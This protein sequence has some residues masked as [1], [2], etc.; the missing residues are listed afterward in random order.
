MKFLPTLMQ[1]PPRNGQWTWTKPPQ[2]HC[3]DQW[4]L[5]RGFPK[6]VIYPPDTFKN[7]QMTEINLNFTFN[8]YP[9]PFSPESSVEALTWLQ[10]L[11]L[12]YYNSNC[13]SGVT[14]VVIDTTGTATAQINN[15]HWFSTKQ[16]CNQCWCCCFHC[17]GWTAVC[18][19]TR[20]YKS[21]DSIA[22]SFSLWWWWW[23]TIGF[24]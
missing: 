1:F 23:V 10:L 22:R 2:Q 24:K 6:P 21:V 12:Y 3:P 18:L 19:V 15:Y 17:L 9:N 11:L 4:L 20:V 8:S 7:A 13:T 14:T 16:Q 5:S